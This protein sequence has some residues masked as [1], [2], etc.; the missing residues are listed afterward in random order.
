MYTI[1]NISR[2]KHWIAAVSDESA[3]SPL[4]PKGRAP[5][6]Q[7][8]YLH[9]ASSEELPASTFAKDINHM[10]QPLGAFQPILLQAEFY[11]IRIALLDSFNDVFVLFDGEM[12]V[13]DD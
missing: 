3:P 8:L 10:A 13:F 4:A 11:S 1:E 6:N 7:M 5:Q 2:L 9:S 12:K